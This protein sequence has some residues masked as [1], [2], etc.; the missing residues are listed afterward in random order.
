MTPNQ[1]FGLSVELWAVELFR[2]AGFDVHLPSYFFQPGYDL[3]LDSF[4]PVHVKA[5]RFR[6]R[7]VRPSLWGCRYQFNLTNLFWNYDYAPALV[8]LV[9]LSHTAGYV[10]FFVP[11]SAFAGRSLVVSITSDPATYRGWLSAYRWSWSAVY[12]VLAASAGRHMLKLP[13]LM[14]V[15]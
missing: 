3:L 15:Y 1:H 9:A 5:A 6:S 11:L 13:L 7:W 10:P 4:L 14:E 12:E 8:V 2:G